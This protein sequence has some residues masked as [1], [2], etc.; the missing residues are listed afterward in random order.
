[1]SMADF[2][3]VVS[4]I[5]FILYVPSSSRKSCSMFLCPSQALHFILTKV[6]QRSSNLSRSVIPVP[7]L[8]K[9]RFC[10]LNSA[11]GVIRG[12]ELA[13]CIFGF[14]NLVSGVIIVPEH[15][16]CT[17]KFRNIWHVHLTSSYRH[18][19]RRCSQQSLSSFLTISPSCCV[20][21]REFCSTSSSTE[22][23]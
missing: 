8:V 20:Y 6:C 10:S 14:L 16:N 11:S 21:G 19:S 18:A 12:P 15:V 5:Q 4:K 9:C 3:L 1:M 22:Y 7:E 23:C 17:F 13:N 2:L